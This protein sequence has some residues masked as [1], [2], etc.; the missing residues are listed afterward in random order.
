MDLN[1]FQPL[2]Q[3]PTVSLSVTATTSNVALT[4]AG[5]LSGQNV[6]IYNKGPGDVF[7]NFGTTA[8][9]SASIS[10]HMVLPVGFMGTFDCP[11]AIKRIAAI[12]NAGES[13]T[14]YASRG[15]GN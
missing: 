13:A 11:G 4:T 3:K 9:T 10:G 14:L 15:N 7:F 12:C 1:A 5:D 2:A 8:N 6:M